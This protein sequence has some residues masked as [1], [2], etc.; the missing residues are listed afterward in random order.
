MTPPPL[1]EHVG[2]VEE[3]EEDEEEALEHLEEEELAVSAGP[4]APGEEDQARDEDNFEEEE[5]EEKEDEDG[6]PAAFPDTDPWVDDKALMLQIHAA[7]IQE[8][9][10]QT[11]DHILKNEREKA[12]EV[13]ADCFTTA[14]EMA[15]LAA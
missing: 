1:G 9:L 7:T 8:M 13:C 12:L 2:E 5:E 10:A 4:S 3:V 11:Y 15:K 14:E 6:G